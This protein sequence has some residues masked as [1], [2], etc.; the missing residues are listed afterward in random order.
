MHV[1]MQAPERVSAV[2]GD[3][4]VFGLWAEYDV[5]KLRMRLKEAA[6]FLR[7]EHLFSRPFWY[8]SKV[9]P[10]RCHVDR[11]FFI[12]EEDELGDDLLRPSRS[13]FTPACNDDVVGAEREI[14]PSGRVHVV[15]C[16]FAGLDWPSSASIWNGGR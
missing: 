15:V 13:R 16:E 11:C 12:T 8:R 10:R 2:A 7:L 4:D 14:V 9:K 5:L 6:V 3:E 1:I